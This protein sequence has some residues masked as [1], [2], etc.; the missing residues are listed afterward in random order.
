M[1]YLLILLPFL[2]WASLGPR[3]NQ[4]IAF[5]AQTCICKD[6][7]AISSN[8]CLR[9]CSEKKTNGAEY[10]F[11]GFRVSSKI[12]KS[13]LRHTQ[14]WCQLVLAQD[15]VNP[16]CVIEAVSWDGRSVMLPV[17]SFPGKN[18]IVADATIL[19]SGEFYMIRLS[20]LSSGSSSL[21]VII[22]KKMKK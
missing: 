16:G 5:K 12:T 10:L 3:P 14:G 2:S 17:I 18:S 20:E 22:S 19:S 4:A 9:F 6:G 1:H 8:Q 15:N 21:P 11:A 13:E 7:E